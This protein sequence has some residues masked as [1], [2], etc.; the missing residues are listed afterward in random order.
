VTLDQIAAPLED[1]T[2]PDDWYVESHGA[3]RYE[4]MYLQVQS[5]TITAMGLGKAYDIYN[6][7]NAEGDA[8]AADYINGDLPLGDKYMPGVGQGK[9]FVSISGILEQYT[10]TSSGWDYYQLLTTGADDLVPVP[11][12][13]SGVILVGGLLLVG[14]AAAGRRK[15]PHTEFARRT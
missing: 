14:L 5:V 6:L 7:R 15:Q 11:E 1:P 2:Q 13:S 3:E 10:K 12:P 9:Q 4:A 8:W